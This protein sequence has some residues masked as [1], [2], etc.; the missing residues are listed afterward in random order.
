[1][2]LERA[3]WSKE[4]ESLF[5]Q[6][7]R[8]RDYAYVRVG[9][10]RRRI[11]LLEDRRVGLGAAENEKVWAIKSKNGKPILQIAGDSGTIAEF[12]PA[13]DGAFSGWWTQFERMPVYLVP[14]E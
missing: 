14:I 8:Q 5:E 2:E 1:F 12:E 4:Q 7:W 6:V 11:E 10:D 9:H 3:A 13:G